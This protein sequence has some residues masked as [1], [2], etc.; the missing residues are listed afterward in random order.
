MTF[1]ERLEILAQLYPQGQ[2]SQLVERTLDK[3]F[4]YE[5]QTCRQQL[6]QLR[7]DLAEFEARYR[8]D[9]DHFFARFQTG[10][11]GDDMDYTEWAS[12]FQMAQKLQQRLRVLTDEASA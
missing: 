1:A 10:E 5:A 6:A 8:M 7:A 9:S 2:V 3:L 12:L 11:M 4:S